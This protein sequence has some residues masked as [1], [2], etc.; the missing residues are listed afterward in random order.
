M[1]MDKTIGVVVPAYNE[2]GFV[3]DVIETLPAFV[4][5]AYVVDD[6]STDGTW[7]EIVAA[8]E[9]ETRERAVTPA[10]VADGGEEAGFVVPIQHEENRG[11]GGAIKTGYLR[12]RDE[13]VD[14]VAVMGGDGQ[15]DPDELERV[16]EPVAA[17]RADYVKGNRFLH[18]AEGMPRIRYAGSVLLTY[19]TRIA[20]GYWHL[21]DP[22]MGYTAISN[23]TLR[24]IDVEEMFE[25]YGY[26]NDLLVR[27]NVAGATVVDVPV[28]TVYGDEES[29]IDLKSY[30]PRVSA[31]LLKMFLWRLV[32]ARETPGEQARSVLYGAG[33]AGTIGGAGAAAGRRGRAAIVAGV[34][35]VVALLAAMLTDA[36]VNR[37][38]NGRDPFAGRED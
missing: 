9:R 18:E 27:L 34:L 15:M 4:D 26:C 38:R 17:G 3:G 22:Q 35:G 28:T 10:M 16:V 20:S 25:F 30:V 8:R 23:E 7:E 2:E 33:A 13:G 31:M 36:Y 11:V 14:V 24:T 5:R 37:H 6:C 19:L 1:Y 12:A 29:G 32:T 21:G